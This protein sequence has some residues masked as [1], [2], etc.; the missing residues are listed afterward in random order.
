MTSCFVG[1]K[2]A[3]V[4]LEF[5]FEEEPSG[6]YNSGKAFFQNPVFP[7]KVLVNNI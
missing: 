5:K 3:L 7:L 1:L 2:V 4:K 6:S